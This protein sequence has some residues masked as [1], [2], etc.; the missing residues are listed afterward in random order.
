M[1]RQ[2]I[3]DAINSRPLTDFVSLQKSPKAGRNMYVCPVCRSGTGKNGTGAL[4]IYPNNRVMCASGGCFGSA[5]GTKTSQDTL[6]ALRIIWGCDENEVFERTGYSSSFSD[7]TSSPRPT[8]ER[9]QDRDFSEFYK[10]AHS[11]LLHSEEALEYLHG[12]GIT[13]ESIEKFNL[14]YDPNWKHSKAPERVAPSKRIIIPRSRRTYVAR[15]IDGVKDDYSKQVEGTQKDIFNITALD[16]A[17]TA[18]L[19]EGELDAISLMQSGAPVV[20]GIGTISNKNLIVTEMR[21]HPDV[22]YSIALDNDPEKEDGSRPGQDAQKYIIKESE[23]SSITVLNVNPSQ[24]YCGEK[25]ANEALQKHPEEL[26]K[27]VS[28]LVSMAEAKRDE[29]DEARQEEMYKR[30]GSGMVDDF[31]L[32]AM[33]REY[34]PVP[35]GIRDI[36]KALGGGFLRKTLVTLGA[37]PAMGK[38]SLCQWILENMAIN[39]HDVLYVNLEMAR[40]QLIARSLSRYA[41]LYFDTDMTSIEVMRG[42][43]WTESQKNAIMKASDKYKREVASH[44]IYNPEGEE[45]EL[46]SDLDS[47]LKAIESETL[48]LHSQGRPSPI[49]CLDYLQLVR[50]NA[51]EDEV[52]V[53]KRALKS[54]KDY[55]VKYNTI[56]LCIVANNRAS[57]RSGISD[58]ESGR[59]TSNLEYSGDMIFGLVYTAID[60]ERNNEKHGGT[61]TL[62]D[63]RKE[64]SNAFDKALREG[65]EPEVPQ[66]CK[67]ITLKVNKN[68]F[69]QD[70][71]KAKLIFDGRHMLYK[72][73]NNFDV[74]STSGFQKVGRNEATPFSQK[75]VKTYG[76]VPLT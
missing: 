65:R 17:R 70:E 62:S 8:E 67:E 1:T 56:V 44:L 24:I 63:I 72:S 47:I 49:I 6:G 38:T 33:S 73:A 3:R 50:G 64:K 14:G 75:E 58:M 54:L 31:L 71:R 12:R 34:E 26:R 18:I 15:R 20:V 40:D 68:R 30:S 59:D 53:I 45:G 41:Y 7:K 25:D 28:A 19:C 23:K 66:V 52:S 10:V 69:G 11:A 4:T 2:E 36:D 37:A 39:G 46:S 48:R 76:G 27:M 21:K 5:D 22:I 51:M 57:N 13:D 74:G 29:Q 9:P 43:E 61:Y 16:G 60:E 35:T 55:A 32:R 42:Y